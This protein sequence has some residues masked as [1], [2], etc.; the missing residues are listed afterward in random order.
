MKWLLHSPA[1]YLFGGVVFVLAVSV[2]AILAYMAEGWSFGDALYMTV[3]TVY[4]VGY[5]EVRPI[6]TPDLRAI[7]IGLIVAGCTGMIFLTG[8]LVQFITIAGVKQLLG[9][10]RMKSQLDKLRDHIVICGFGR[11]GA[12]LARELQAARRDFVIIERSEPRINEARVLGYLCI[13]GDA[14]DDETLRQAGIARARALATVLPQDSANVFI[15][16]S[17]RSLNREIQIIAR[18]EAPFTESKLLQAGANDVVMPAYT[19]AERVAEMILF[20]AAAQV[21]ESSRKR[22]LEQ[23]LHV[24]GLELE[25]VVAEAGSAFVG[26]TVA[27]IERRA[28]RAFMIV[29]IDRAATGQSERPKRESRIESGDG[30][31]IVGRGGRAEILGSFAART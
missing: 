10:Q 22:R 7:T 16:L 27:E 1:R 13:Q 9:Q 25:T 2:L 12:M 23:D 4:T 21:M 19:G 31:M 11:I 28:D 3:L 18:G 6:D 5:D 15:T 20:P 29:A 30:V 26:L 8:A 24:L 17:A 14:T